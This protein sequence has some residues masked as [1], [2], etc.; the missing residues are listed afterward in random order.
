MA[1][2]ASHQRKYLFGFNETR[3]SKAQVSG[4]NASLDVEHCL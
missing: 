3:N 1:A 4:V 2:K